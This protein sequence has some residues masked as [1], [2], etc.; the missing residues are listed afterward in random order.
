MKAMRW[1]IFGMAVS[2]A[3]PALAADHLDVKPGLWSMTMQTQMGGVPNVDL[4]KVPVAQRAIVQKMMAAQMGKAAKPKAFES[5]LTE[6]DLS[7]PL[8]FQGENDPLCKVSVKKI[9]ASEVQYGEECTGAHARSVT[10]DFKAANE[11]SVSGRSRAVSQGVTVEVAISGKWVGAD[12]GAVKPGHA[13]F[14]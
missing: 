9:T 10:T 6:A 11:E 14:Q 13:Q 8:A 12:C 7:K 2:A 3:A 4:S 5:C 1:V